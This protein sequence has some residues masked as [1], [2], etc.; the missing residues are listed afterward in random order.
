MIQS[1]FKIS[2]NSPLLSEK[3][4]DMSRVG[5]RVPLLRCKVLDV[6]SVDVLVPGHGLPSVNVAILALLQG[7]QLVKPITKLI[8]GVKHDGDTVVQSVESNDKSVP[9]VSG[10]KLSVDV[11]TIL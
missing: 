8:L 1:L 9:R 4:I 2:P 11:E 5:A 10:V 3:K 7:Q 6:D